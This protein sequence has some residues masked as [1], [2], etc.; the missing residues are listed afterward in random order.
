MAIPDYQMIMLPLLEHL[1]DKRERSSRETLDALVKALSLTE[2]ECNELL[3]SGRQAVFTNRVA[4]AKVYLKKAGL[5]ESPRRGMYRITPRGLNVL[6]Q[7]PL[8]IDNEFLKQ[9]PE[10]VDLVGGELPEVQD[11]T[12]SPTLHGTLVSDQTPEEQLEEAY[13]SIRH[14]LASELLARIKECSPEFFEYLVVDLLVKM[15]YGG[16]HKDAA[17]TVGR[18]GDGGI[19]GII[20]E[21][22]LGLETIYIQAKRW[23]GVVGR[24]EIQQFAGALQGQRARKGVFITTSDFSAAAMNYARAID[25]RI[26][27]VNGTQLADL[28]I[29]YDIGVTTV[30]SYDVKKIDLDYFTEE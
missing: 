5:I 19:D 6:Q 17:A 8:T 21:D 11:H 9:F 24:P 29:T 30:T 15:G 1:A 4:W 14:Q 20:K 12:D 3:P 13:G 23:V 28:L 16:S 22:R 26:V 27:L 10:F 7:K 18:S 25:N 2:E